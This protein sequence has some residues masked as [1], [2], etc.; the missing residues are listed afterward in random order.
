MSFLFSKR[1]LA[2]KSNLF[3]M[4]SIFYTINHSDMGS[5]GLQHLS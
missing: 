5:H 4:N 3:S 2:G 1:I